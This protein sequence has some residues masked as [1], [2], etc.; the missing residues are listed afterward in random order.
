MYLESD[1][2]ILKE[3]TKSNLIDFYKLKSEEKVW[4][5]STFNPIKKLEDA[6][7]SLEEHVNKYK[8]THFIH[9]AI[10]L[11]DSLTFIGE[12]GIL[13]YNQNVDRCTVGYNLLPEYWNKGY[14]TEIVRSLLEY[15]FCYL[16]CERVEAI[17]MKDNGASCRVLE[18][19]GFKL[20]G[21]LRNFTKLA[22]EYKDVCFY[23]KLSSD[24]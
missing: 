3:Y 12:A 8:K 11:K 22:N 13:S 5:Y 6:V 7:A 1:N 21:I 17:V 24:I 19:C 4:K 9:H 14:A 23:A 20:E 18:K 16:K 15:S 10:F 2:L